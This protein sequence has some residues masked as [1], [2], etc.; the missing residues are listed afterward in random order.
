MGDHHMPLDY[1]AISGLAICTLLALVIPNI[2]SL[3]P[4]GL[5]QSSQGAV[6]LPE[7]EQTANITAKLA[8]PTVS[9]LQKRDNATLEAAL[10]AAVMGAFLAD[11]AALGLHGCV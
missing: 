9:Q 11:A 10:E 2:P 5:S 3:Q 8:S 7:H 4:E 6:I 1:T